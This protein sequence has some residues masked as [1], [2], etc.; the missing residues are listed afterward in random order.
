[1]NEFYDTSLAKWDAIK[2]I[3]IYKIGIYI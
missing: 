3:E 1:M 2:P